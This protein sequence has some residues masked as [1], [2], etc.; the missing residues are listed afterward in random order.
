MRGLVKLSVNKVITVIMAILAVIVFGVVSFNRL[1]TDLF[2]DIDIPYAVVVTTYPGANPEEVEEEVS[3]PLEDTLQATTNV[4]E[5]ISNSRENMSMITLEF[6]QGT[7]MDTALVEMRED[8]NMI[9]DMLPDEVGTPIILRLNPEMLP[10]MNFSVSHEEM[11]LE[12]LTQYVEDTMAPRIERVPG[13]ANLTITGGHESEM[14]VMLDQDAIDEYNEQIENLLGM[15]NDDME[16]SIELNKEYVSTILMAQ[17]FSFPAG[18]VEIDGMEYMVRVGDEIEDLDEIRELKIFGFE[19]VPFPIDIPT[20]TIDDIAEVEMVEADERQYSKVNGQDAMTISVQ[21]TTE[22][23]TTDV[24]EGVNEALA[25]LE[26][27]EEGFTS[28]MLLDQ[29]EYINIATSNV[30]QNLIVGGILA[31]II[32]LV[33]L[34]SFRM[35][36]IVGVAIPI[37]LLF[38]I[39]LMYLSDITLNI[40]SLGGL[41]LGIGMLVDNS[42][43]VI[44]NIFRMK[45]DGATNKDAALNGATQVGGA[46]IAST[47]TTIA[48][49]IP[50]MFIEDFIRDIFYQLALTVTFSL[51]A[52]LLIALTFVPSVANRMLKEKDKNIGASDKKPL[53]EKIKDIYS[54]VLSGFFMVRYAV[55]GIVLALFV[56]TFFLATSRGFE[57]FPPTDEGA[58]IVNIEM[59]EEDPMDF[60]TFTET[61]N[62]LSE[63]IMAFEDVASVGVSLDDQMAMFGFGGFGGAVGGDQATVNIVLR[64]DR[65]L[66]TVDMQQEIETLFEEDYDY[67]EVEIMGAEMDADM[68]IGEGIQVRIRGEDLDA[69]REEALVIAEDLE[70]IEGIDHVDPGLGRQTNEVRISVDKDAAIE[71]G[72]T[73]AQVYQATSEYLSAPETVTDIRM[74]GRSFDIYVYDEGETPRTEIEDLESIESLKVGETMLE[75]DVK[76]GEIADVSIQ[77][78]FETIRR[79]DG[80]RAFTVDASIET[81]YN[82]SLVAPDVE[83]YMED[84]ELPAGYDYTILGEDEEIM[85]AIDTLILVGVIGILLVYMVMASQF[86]SFVYPFI[87]MVTLPLAFTGGFGILYLSGN[88]VSI[89][90]LIGLIILAGVVVNNGIVLVDYINQLRERGFELKRAIFEAGRIRLRPI[91]MTALTTILALLVLAIGVGEGTELTQPMAL[92]AIGGL[93]YATFLTIFVVPIMYYELTLRGRYI[94]GTLIAL[95]F[96]GIGVYYLLSSHWYEYFGIWFPLYSIG[97]FALTVVTVLLTIFLPKRKRPASQAPQEADSE[98]DDILKEVLRD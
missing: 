20:I 57:F 79:V 53:L 55:L 77:P 26:E 17:N 51:I 58:L 3:M 89:V 88:P 37:S 72:L 70:S 40:V 69:L 56:G 90:A 43:V 80:A 21:K 87:I 85:D 28:T 75:E 96:A 60:D 71:K 5:V 52:S 98:L 7:N 62:S 91:F 42:V 93:A 59:D 65:E 24:T 27:E 8:M 18:F 16:E 14:R 39:I 66:T 36:F 61:L 97:A 15:F 4:Q 74:E 84:R 12:E 23:A 81:G 22:H 10:V 31:I 38:A 29:G 95:I 25:D 94:M 83:E 44:E 47:L 11:D 49:F 1:T 82:A 9:A 54:R 48:V 41:A 67:F 50:I 63:D 86:Q 32:L 45:R 30:M 76:L 68:L 13:V 33:F 34:R 92:T 64:E 46:I 78:G 19:E 2:P 6:S 73:V 35:T